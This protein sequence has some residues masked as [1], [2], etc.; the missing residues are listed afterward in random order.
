M[1]V[2]AFHRHGLFRGRK[3]GSGLRAISY[4]FVIRTST[5]RRT[6]TKWCWEEIYFSKTRVIA[7][8]IEAAA[9]AAAAQ[10]TPGDGQ[11][12]PARH[13]MPACFAVVQR[14]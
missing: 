12:Q 9:A 6:S 3:T 11:R 13:S 5:C 4:S 2:G 10:P 7:A 1:V 8:A 14:L